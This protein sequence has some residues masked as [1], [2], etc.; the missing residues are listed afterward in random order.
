MLSKRSISIC[1]GLL[2]LSGVLLPLTQTTA[3]DIGTE[4]IEYITGSPAATFNDV[5][6][7]SDGTFALFVGNT[8]TNGVVYRYDRNENTWALLGGGSPDD[9]YRGVDFNEASGTF[10]V[11]GDPGAT[12]YP[13]YTTDGFS[14]LVAAG[15]FGV[16]PVLNDVTAGAVSNTFMAVGN[17]G[18]A[19]WLNPSGTWIS[20]SGPAGDDTLTGV[21]FNGTHFFVVGY[22]MAASGLGFFTTE[23]ELGNGQ[24]TLA[25][26][27]GTPEDVLNDIAWSN[28]CEGSPNNMGLGLVAADGNIW[29]MLNPEPWSKKNPATVPPGRRNHA[30]SWDS[31]R[32]RAIVFGGSSA[33]SFDDTWEYDPGSDQWT[34]MNPASAPSAR[35]YPAMVYDKNNNVHILFGGKDGAGVD[36]ETWVYNYNTNT[37]TQM[38]P[39]SSPPARSQHMMV[40]DERWGVVVLFGG[41]DGASTALGDTWVYEY[42]TNT[43]TQMTPAG[44]PPNRFL[45]GMSYDSKNYVTILYGGYGT[46]FLGDTWAYDYNA[47]TWTL[48][49]PAQSPSPRD[50]HAM[51]FDPVTNRTIVWGGWSG[52]TE[53]DTWTY[54]YTSNTWTEVITPTRPTGRYDSRMVGTGRGVSVFFG[55]S[56]GNDETWGLDLDK[57]PWG[58]PADNALGE[59]FTGV[60]WEPNGKEALIIGFNSSSGTGV[61]Y[62]FYEYDNFVTKV[63]DPLKAMS[64]HELFGIA[65]STT[66]PIYGL[67][68]GGSAMKVWTNAFDDTTTI[69]AAADSAHVF[70]IDMWKTSDGVFGTSLIDQMVNVETTHTFYALV[71]YTVAGV[72]ELTN[73]DGN[74]AL[75]VSAWYDEG[76]T[77]SQSGPESNWNTQDNR[78][79]QFLC[80]WDEENGV[81]P[82]TASMIYPVGSPGTDEFT[83]ES[84]WMDPTPRGLDGSQRRFYFNVSFGP[85]SR[86]ADGQ[87]FAFGTGAPAYDNNQMLNDPFSWDLEVR[88]YDTASASSNSSYGEFGIYRFTNITVAGNPGGSAPPGSNDV[89]LGISQITYSANVPHYLNVSIPDLGRVGGGGS[90]PATN[91]KVRSLSPLVDDL[92]S[93]IRNMKAFPGSN[94]NLSVWGNTSQAFG[95]WVVDAPMNGT[96]AHGPWGSDYNGYL[97]TDIEWFITIPT[98]TS[99]GV[100]QESIKFVLSYYG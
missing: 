92:N 51:T 94:Q 59:T 1:I 54:D 77:A 61:V 4:P 13:A 41:V 60:A 53:S 50:R 49:N 56:I 85:Q 48:K 93:E 80:R 37:W 86:A 88:L 62:T 7:H 21:D 3:E 67:V 65:Y 72:N 17:S 66:T 30:M 19:E 47:D 18:R 28:N 36:D 57:K 79:R 71:N 58:G 2:F 8:S 24:F 44:S 99:E 78:T 83:L 22:S 25:T 52:S 38:F 32:N 39:A 16:N 82:A 23:G 91:V 98:G 40:F 5:A 68:A 43:W 87:G 42:S 55:G 73:G 64:G 100:Y 35:D 14:N 11:V 27:T 84:W 46:G 31:G 29:G 9:I 15:S 20:L 96:T 97:T 70:E 10:M 89:P 6:W 34:N 74:T 63:D 69:T 90:I 75:E 33:L 45:H 26:V 12:G 81:F 95:N 76:K